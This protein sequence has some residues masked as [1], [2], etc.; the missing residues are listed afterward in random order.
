MLNGPKPV[1]LS[2]AVTVKLTVPGVV[3]VP[4][5]VPVAVLNERPVGSVPELVLML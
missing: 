5:S 1:E 2:V 3:G 4:A